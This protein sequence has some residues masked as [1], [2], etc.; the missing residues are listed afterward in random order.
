MFS[1]LSLLTLLRM[2]V[3]MPCGREILFQNTTRKKKKKE[4]VEYEVYNISTDLPL[5][6][7]S[8]T[9]LTQLVVGKKHIFQFI[10]LKF[11]RKCVKI[12]QKAQPYKY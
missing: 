4:K 11:T 7:P 2:R 8:L 1:F 5:A 12:P 9:T 6:R 3:K 10:L